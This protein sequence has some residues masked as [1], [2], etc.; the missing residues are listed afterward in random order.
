MRLKSSE[1]FSDKPSSLNLSN[2]VRG[3]DPINSA[4]ILLDG[5][6]ATSIERLV[7]RET[8]AISRRNNTEFIDVVETRNQQPTQRQQNRE[9]STDGEFAQLHQQLLN[10]G[11]QSGS[12]IEDLFRIMTLL[13]SDIQTKE[14]ALNSFKTE[15]LKRLI[16]PIEI[17]K[18]TLANAYIE[19]QD[20]I[21][22]KE[23]AKNCNIKP[24]QRSPS[25]SNETNLDRVAGKN[26]LEE[27][28][29]SSDIKK[30]RLSKDQTESDEMSTSKMIDGEKATND[31]DEI[32]NIMIA[33]LELLDRH[34]LLALPRDAMYCL[35][36]ACNDVSTKNYLNLKIQSLENLI[37]QHR[38]FRY[39]MSERL[40]RS[41]Q[42]YMDL[43]IKLELER[44][45]E[46][47][48]ERSLYRSSGKAVL[49]SHI[50]Q[51]K[52][53]LEKEKA[54]KHAIVM[55]LLNEL[56]DERE[57]NATL[58]ERVI[59]LEKKLAGSKLVSQP[60]PAAAVSNKPRVPAKP[61]QL[62]DRQRSQTKPGP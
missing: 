41:E 25:A 10:F 22:A 59:D 13:K 39:Y 51:L 46:I 36:Y 4:N 47:E 24:K 21:E 6:A 34:P 29:T 19:L 23:K 7:L 3:D 37:D 38:R 43:T 56:L 15:Q 61:A 27:R 2:V 28:E 33:L 8:E 60:Q 26:S 11:K 40:K 57:R 58:Q 18:S 12:A 14:I 32:L 53:A 62:L 17:K 54:S 5:E 44:H 50:D 9:Q 45:K 30:K 48:N 35:D 55:T 20:R 49:L 1:D 31:D 42:R 16:N 52:E